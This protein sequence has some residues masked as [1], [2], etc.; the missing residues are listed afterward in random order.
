MTRVTNSWSSFRSVYLLVWVYL[1]IRTC[2]VFLC[3]VARDYEGLLFVAIV[4]V[5]SIML[6]DFFVLAFFYVTGVSQVSTPMMSP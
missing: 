3:F 1:G 5:K 6:T 4:K 2:E